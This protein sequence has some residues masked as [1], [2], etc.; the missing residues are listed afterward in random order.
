MSTR[1]AGGEKP[2]AHAVFFPLPAQ[3]HVAAALHLAKLLHVRGGVRVT[4]VHSDRNRRRLVRSRGP[5][6]LAGTP[7]FRFAAVP[8]GL[9][10]PPSDEDDDDHS[11][12][13]FVALLSSIK[14]SVPHLK[15]L[16]DDTATA[17]APATCVVSDIEC[18]LLAAREVGLPAVAFWTTS[19]CGL[20]ASLQCQQLIDKGLVPLKNAEQLSNGYLEGTVVDSVP[21]MPADMRLRDFVSF[22]RTTDPD[23][24]MLGTV[25]RHMQCLR[26]VPSA[27]ILNTLDELEGEVVAAL[28][29]ILPPIYTVGLL[30]LL[31]E[32][33]VAGSPLDTLRANLAREDDSCLEWLVSKRPRS[34][35]YV[36]FGSIAVLT[37]QQLVEFAWGLANSGYEFLMVI[38][39]VQ[40][41][42]AGGPTAMLPLELVEET[43]ERGYITSWCPQREVL[44]HEAVGAFLTHCG[45]NS[46]LES[47]TSGVPMLCWPFGAEQPT[48]CRFAC[49]EW[50]VGVEIGGDV[51][52]GEV[53]MLVREIMGGEKGK[54]MRQRAAEWKERA[55][56]AASLPGGSS[57]VTLERLVREVFQAHHK[58]DLD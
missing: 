19:A 10:L 33:V 9:P 23:D 1:A 55:A 24:A 3:G 30:P 32:R 56:A 38:R 37:S 35:V 27:I 17:G 8:D 12:H 6:A 44:R 25:L 45:W 41:K 57:W 47:I 43:K 22:I 21:G 36:N 50:R 5:D 20:M 58:D 54:E 13:H 52:R 14:A 26:I 29:A 48:N 42:G 31:A 51:K 18:V 7:S 46:M 49:T 39:D 2:A 16:L 28:L 34:V 40:A 15:N 11:P 53:E 4:F